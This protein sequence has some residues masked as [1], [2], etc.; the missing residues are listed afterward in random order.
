M[1]N[2]PNRSRTSPLPIADELD[3]LDKLRRR[4]VLTQEEF[5]QQKTKLLA[6]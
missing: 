1:Q 3:K 5:D 2:P 6:R 4:G